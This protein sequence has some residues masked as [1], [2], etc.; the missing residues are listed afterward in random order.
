MT[1][2]LLTIIAVTLL[3]YYSFDKSWLFNWNGIREEIKDTV[4]IAQ[5]KLVSGRFVG[6]GGVKSSQY[7]RR[8]WIMK[9]ATVS[10]L[11]KLTDYPNGTIKTIAYEGLLRKPHFHDKSNIALKAISETDYFTNYES[12]CMVTDMTIGEYIVDYVLQIGDLSPPPPPGG[13]GLK[14]G[15]SEEEC[16]KLLNE[17][18]KVPGLLRKNTLHNKAYN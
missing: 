18:R 11:L 14:F 3:M 15:I 9:T 8:K 10:E 5:N 17:Y 1:F 2:P 4:K 6:E 16:E 7:N 13:F 12:G